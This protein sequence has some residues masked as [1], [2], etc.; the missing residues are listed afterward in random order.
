MLNISA[1]IWHAFRAYKRISIGPVE[2]ISEE[3]PELEGVEN[4][5]KPE[6]L[7]STEIHENPQTS[8]NFRAPKSQENSDNPEDPENRELEE[9]RLTPTAR[10][11]FNDICLLV[12]QQGKLFLFRDCLMK[13]LELSG[14]GSGYTLAIDS[15]PNT[16]IKYILIRKVKQRFQSRN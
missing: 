11:Q 8:E 3:S 9:L 15:E 12:F 5:D 10:R 16:V 14:E 7:E 13:S 2:D 6:H 4:L 1:C